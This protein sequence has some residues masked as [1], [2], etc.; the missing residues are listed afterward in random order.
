MCL[1]CRIASHEANAKVVYEDDD[2][3]AFHDIRPQAPTHVLVI[4]RKHV[5]SLEHAQDADEALLGKLL[6]RTRAIART[7]GLAEG[8][9]RVVI[10]TGDDAGQTVPHVHAH[11]V[12]G[13]SLRWPP[14]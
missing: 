13:R 11:L 10:N 5:Q 8:G 7:L 4:P 1:F 14:G 6:L 2:V 12:G 3:V 9:Y